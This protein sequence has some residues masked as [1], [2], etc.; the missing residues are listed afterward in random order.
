[1]EKNK[2]DL[3]VESTELIESSDLSVD[4]KSEAI[5]D[6]ESMT[7]AEIQDLINGG[8]ESLPSPDLE[9]E[10]ESEDE[11]DDIDDI[12]DDDDQAV[13]TTKKKEET[14]YACTRCEFKGRKKL[15]QCPTCKYPL[16]EWEP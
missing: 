7:K 5:S 15:D 13:P 1:M 4:Q 2:A 16:K 11:S 6:L 3:I 10:D 9:S 12:L 14:I 8:M